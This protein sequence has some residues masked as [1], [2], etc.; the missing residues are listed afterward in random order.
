LSYSQAENAGAYEIVNPESGI[1]TALVRNNTSS[2]NTYSIMGDTRSDISL[3]V[4]PPPVSHPIDKPLLLSATLNNY[5]TPITNSSV[6]A[7]LSG[8]NWQIEVPLYD[9]GVH[10]DGSAADGTYANYLYPF[11]SG[12]NV[13]PEPGGVCKLEILAEMPSVGARRSHV[14]QI[15][16]ENNNS[17]SYP[18]NNRLLSRGWN[19]VGFP[20]LSD[21]DGGNMIPSASI[22]LMPYLEQIVSANGSAI[23]DVAGWHYN[24]LSL[25]NSVSGYKLLINDTDQAHLFDCGA[26]TDTTSAYPLQKDI[27]NW[28]TYPCFSSAYPEDAL[29]NVINNVDY[30]MAQNWSMK[31]ENGIWAKDGNSHIPILRYGDSVLIHANENVDLYWNPASEPPIEVEPLGNNHYN[32]VSKP[33]YETLMI[34]SVVLPNDK[35]IKEIGVF[36]G[37]VCIGARV[38]EGFPLQVLAY[39]ETDRTGSLPLEIRALTTDDTEIILKPNEVWDEHGADEANILNPEVFGFRHLSLKDGDQIPTVLSMNKNYPNPFNPSTTIR[40]AI[41]KAGKVKL[42]IYNL[43][44]QKVRVLVN[45]NIIP[46]YYNSIWDGR[47]KNNRNVSSGVYFARL[48]HNNKTK[49]QKMVLLK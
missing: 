26:I 7:R 36:Q 16:I 34:E 37:Q 45:D 17:Y 31:K 12:F 19:W 32:I 18:I 48:E 38:V 5:R 28:L 24:G 46:G 11:A 44:G 9:T 27:W 33:D 2:A 39:S 35:T 42:E 23:Y 13:I 41:P 21:Y 20:R 47:D 49:I 14:Q 40:Y 30:I 29:A 6:I 15:Y 22:S 25:L 1:W 43:K 4:S 3:S 10:H 8:D